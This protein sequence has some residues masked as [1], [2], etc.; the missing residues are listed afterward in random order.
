ME[1]LFCDNHILAAVKPPN[2]PSQADA[3]RDLDMLT[4]MK[5]YIGIKYKK[6][7]NV[8]LG[9]VHRLD[10]PAGGVMVF[11]RTSKAASRLSAQFR[12]HLQ[13][14]KYFAVVEGAV[15]KPMHLTDYLV[16]DADGMV[17]IVPEGTP[18]AKRAELIT[19]PIATHDTHTLMD[20]EL[21]TG[22]AHQ[23]RVQHAHAGHPL[24]G[25]MR[26]GNGVPGRQLALWAYAL[27]LTHP[28]RDEILTFQSKPPRCGAW[29]EFYDIINARFPHAEG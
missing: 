9:L 10:R 6:P 28:T 24:W 5:R 11:A 25:D 15:E 7:G 3:S 20:V 18:G 27:S 29:E 16:K 19:V 17:R 26:Y 8:Y 12:A 13:G 14:R 2:M 23:I 1:V 22:R 4:E 21:M